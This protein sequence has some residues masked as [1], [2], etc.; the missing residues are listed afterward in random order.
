MKLIYMATT[1]HLL[2]KLNGHEFTEKILS[3]SVTKKSEKTQYLLV[4]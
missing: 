2:H 4:K 1:F 3:N